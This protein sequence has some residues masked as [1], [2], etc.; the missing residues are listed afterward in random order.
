MKSNIKIGEGE[1]YVIKAL[2]ESAPFSGAQIVERVEKETDWSQ[3]TIYTM[4]RRLHAK[5]VIK[6]DN[7]DVMLY[8]P[9]ISRQEAEKE[10]T[11]TFI[12]RVY[13]GSVQM[14]VKGFIKENKLSE[15][16]IREL[17]SLLDQKERE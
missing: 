16:D 6:G 10:E 9:V 11:E 3:S 17:R 1:W 5:G 15:E 12:K 4:I 13:A 14:M 7:Q 2:W 8:A